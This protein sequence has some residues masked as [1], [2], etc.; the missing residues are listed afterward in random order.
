MPATARDEAARERLPTFDPAD[1]RRP[2]P[3]LH[4][5]AAHLRRLLDGAGGRWEVALAAY[6]AGAHAAGRWTEFPESRTPEGFVE[7]IPFRETRAYVK[8]V[9][10]A[11]ARYE[12][13]HGR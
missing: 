13:L 11:R 3:N 12:E 4:L 5:G 1:L 2:E 9:L 8:L 6:N 7:R 10:A